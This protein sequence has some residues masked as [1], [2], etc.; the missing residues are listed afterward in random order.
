MNR[1]GSVY[2]ALYSFW[3]ARDAALTAL[4]GRGGTPPRRDAYSVILFNEMA[5]IAIQN[6]FTAS[7]DQL[8]ETLLAHGPSGGTN[9]NAALGEADRV[10][11][12]NWSNERQVST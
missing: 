1:L 2:S 3:T 10:L 6:D 8:L 7:P 5:N 9:F 4:A 11:E 12:R